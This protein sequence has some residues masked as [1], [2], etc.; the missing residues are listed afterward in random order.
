MEPSSP[1]AAKPSDTWR[2]PPRTPHS[3]RASETVAD[4]A[5]RQRAYTKEEVIELIRRHAASYDLDPALP[6][7]IARCESGF[8]WDARNPNSSAAGVMQYLNGTWAN[9][10]AGRAGESVFDADA[11]IRMA[12]THIAIHGTAP[13]N[14]SKSCWNT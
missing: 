2:V 7:A 5:L 6:L 12:V 13:W 4:E 1:R 3:L 14:A 10:S 9:T 11:N 8:R